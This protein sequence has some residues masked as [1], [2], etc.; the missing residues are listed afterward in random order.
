MER[1]LPIIVAVRL[2]PAQGLDT[3]EEE[4]TYTDNISPCGARV[5]SKHS[6]ETGEIVKLTSL[7]DGSVC[8]QVVYCQKLQDDRYALGLHVLDRPIPWSVIGRFWET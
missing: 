4:K 3:E 6:W 1:R 7:H 2:V 8:G 5:F